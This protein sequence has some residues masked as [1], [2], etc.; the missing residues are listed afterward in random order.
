MKPKLAFC[1]RGICKNFDPLYSNYKEKLFDPLS[2]TYDIDYF[3]S[4]NKLS[5]YVSTRSKENHEVKWDSIL[6][7]FNF[8]NQIIL[9]ENNI[10]FSYLH[11]FANNLVD[12][13]GGFWGMTP[14]GWDKDQSKQNTFFAMKNLY[15]IFLLKFIV[16]NIYDKYIITRQDL[17]FNHILNP[18]LLSDT[19]SDA[20][21][22]SYFSWGGY[23][24]RFAIL[25]S[26]AFEIYTNRLISILTNPQKYH[27][28]RYLKSNCLDKFK[29]NVRLFDNF[30]F[31]AVR[32]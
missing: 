13:Y 1:F 20:I 14:K 29:I 16:P 21:I 24:D 10:I 22:P 18:E 6:K 26:K 17:F 8:K 23:C 32:F 28:E 4:T 30:T 19:T 9:E 3:L 11:T 12:N 2:Q 15:S 5:K 31:Q 7:Y 27:E 25:N